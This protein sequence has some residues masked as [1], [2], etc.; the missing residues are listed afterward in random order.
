MCRLVPDWEGWLSAEVQRLWR[1]HLRHAAQA[2]VD[3]R[4]ELGGGELLGGGGGE[5]A[6]GAYVRWDDTPD[7]EWRWYLVRG[8]EGDPSGGRRC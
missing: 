4:T 6:E 7:K 2:Q 8:W 3:D 5:A 1:V